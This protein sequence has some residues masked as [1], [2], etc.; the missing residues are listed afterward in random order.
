MFIF[1]QLNDWIQDF[2]RLFWGLFYRARYGFVFIKVGKKL[3]IIPPF[4]ISP[5]IF[6]SKSQLKITL[7]NYVYFN[8]GVILQGSGHLSIG[9]W[10]KIGAYSI[11]GCNQKITIG[12]A[13]IMASGVS[14][15]DTDHVFLDR[16]K[17]IDSQGIST[18]PVI[19]EDDVWIGSNV[20]ITKGVTIGK[21]AIIGANAVVTHNVIPFSVVG[22]VPATIIKMRP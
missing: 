17:Y 16:N 5:F 19:I 3:H 7:G 22:G 4:L 10:S 8:K 6:P 1:Y 9:D 21:G 14:I 13:V 11:I 20:T 12:R 15:R 18:D 2:S